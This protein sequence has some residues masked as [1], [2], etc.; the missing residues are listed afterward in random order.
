MGFLLYMSLVYV[1]CICHLAVSV[2]G[3]GCI[4]RIE[5]NNH[6]VTMAHG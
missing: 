5:M 3:H 6:H 1:C 4:V 2:V